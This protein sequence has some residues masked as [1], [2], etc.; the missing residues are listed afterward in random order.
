MKNFTLDEW[1]E[2]Q[3]KLHSSNMDFNLSRIKEV[4]S[5][6]NIS[7]TK[8]KVFTVHLGAWTASFFQSCPQRAKRARRRTKIERQGP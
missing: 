5:R 2:W 6:L 3:C 1:I 7:Q 4:A 8:K